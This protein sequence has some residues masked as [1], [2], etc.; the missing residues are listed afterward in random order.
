MAEVKKLGILPI[1]LTPFDKNEEL[2]TERLG[3]EIDW[4]VEKLAGHRAVLLFYG[5]MGAYMDLNE[6]ERIKAFEAAVVHTKGR[7]PVMLG[8]S[9]ANQTRRESV[10]Y[11][12]AAKDAGADMLL[13][14]TPN[15]LSTAGQAGAAREKVRT[16]VFEYFRA[17]HDAVDIPI[18]V[19]N[20]GAIQDAQIFADLAEKGYIQYLKECVQTPNRFDHLASLTDKL[21]CWMCR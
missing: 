8:V 17:V 20:T 9:D 3:Q 16:E 4:V 2:N 19:Y 5:S 1:V 14:K 11:A 18:C 7:Y 6:A 13:L 10:R 21:H 12:R 15:H